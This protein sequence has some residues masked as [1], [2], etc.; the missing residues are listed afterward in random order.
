MTSSPPAPAIVSSPVPPRMV[1]ARL[2]P[3]NALMSVVSVTF[4][5][6]SMWTVA[7]ADV[8][9]PPSVAVTV[10]VRSAGLKLNV[11]SLSS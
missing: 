11:V 4:A 6:R 10:M 5:A 7:G 9:P 2:E 8:A 3:V 1:S